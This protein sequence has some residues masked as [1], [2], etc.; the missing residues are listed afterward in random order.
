M[1]GLQVHG[2]RKVYGSTAVVDNVSFSAP[3]GRI[4]GVLGP[5]GAG[6]PPSSA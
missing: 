6:K 3:Q 4:L 1:D 2:I 5:N